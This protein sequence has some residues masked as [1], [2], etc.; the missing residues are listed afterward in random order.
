MED[1]A[2]SAQYVDTVVARLDDPDWV[3]R[4]CALDTLGNLEPAALA[5]H[6][7]AVVA[8]LDDS[9]GYVRRTL[10]P[11]CGCSRTPIGTCA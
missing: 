2:A 4:S 1:L 6:A 5:Q 8:R 10:M 3:V 7:D 11:S 9:D